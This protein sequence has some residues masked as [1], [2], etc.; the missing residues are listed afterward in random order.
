MALQRTAKVQIT[1]SQVLAGGVHLHDNPFIVALRK[2]PEVGPSA[3]LIDMGNTVY[4][5]RVLR[6]GSR[7]FDQVPVNVRMWLFNYFQGVVQPI[8]FDWQLPVPL[9]E[10]MKLNKAYKKLKN[11]PSPRKNPLKKKRKKRWIFKEKD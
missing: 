4:V 3:E 5:V 7:R 9:S 11:F 10:Q 6:E 2:I 8:E 1:L